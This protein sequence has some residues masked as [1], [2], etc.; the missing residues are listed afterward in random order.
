MKS[1]DLLIELV[2]VNTLEHPIHVLL[3]IGKNI[4]HFFHFILGGSSAEVAA[5][6]CRATETFLLCDT[7]TFKLIV[8]GKLSP[9]RNI[10]N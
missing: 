4:S 10:V 6:V 5:T 3:M 9:L 2:N 7:E 1:A 8:K